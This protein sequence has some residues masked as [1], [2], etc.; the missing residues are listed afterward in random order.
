MDMNEL[1]SFGKRLEYLL[2]LKGIPKQDLASAINVS[3]TTISNYIND[4]RKPDLTVLAK[5][6][7]FLNVNSDFLLMRT[8]DFTTYIKKEV[9]GELIEITFDDEKLHLTSDE[10]NKLF[11]QLKPFGF[12]PKNYFDSNK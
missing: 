3:P 8:N 5:I 2:D 11:E 6:A 1:N 9:E 4:N 7:D 12:N 10:I